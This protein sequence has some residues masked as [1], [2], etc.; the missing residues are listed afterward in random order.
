MQE[1][2]ARMWHESEKG[3]SEGKPPSRAGRAAAPQDV[4]HTLLCLSALMAP[5][6][7]LPSCCCSS[8]WWCYRAV[9][10][11]GQVAMLGHPT[12]M[13]TTL[14]RQFTH[15]IKEMHY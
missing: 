2:T 8:C 11:G 9:R 6:I 15:T 7:A 14:G 5:A 12:N 10:R 4:R 13:V 1:A 3:V